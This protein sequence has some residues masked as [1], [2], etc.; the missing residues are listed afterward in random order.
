MKFEF[1]IGNITTDNTKAENINFKI[2][3]GSNELKETYSLI[4]TAIKEL[5]ETMTQL[6][7]AYD[8]VNQYNV[9]ESKGDEE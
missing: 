1:T 7:S 9:E 4:K 2:E 5:P 6:K 3:C 8:L